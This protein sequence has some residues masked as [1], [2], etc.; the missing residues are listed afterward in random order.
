MLLPVLQKLNANCVWETGDS[1]GET[2]DFFVYVTELKS[3]KF[4]L[5]QLQPMMFIH[6]HPGGGAHVRSQLNMLDGSPEYFDPGSQGMVFLWDSSCLIVF[7]SVILFVSIFCAFLSFL[8]SALCIL[9]VKCT[10]YRIDCT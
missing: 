8:L 6:L 7:Y 9:H 10:S 3:I 1:T 2:L 4:S 5:N